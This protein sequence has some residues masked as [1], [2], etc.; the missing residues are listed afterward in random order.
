MDI[1]KED[2]NVKNVK[3]VYLWLTTL[4]VQLSCA[5]LSCAFI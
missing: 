4:N 1:E 5:H 2:K 3:N